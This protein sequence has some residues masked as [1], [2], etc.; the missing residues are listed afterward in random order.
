MR[1][2][3]D[4]DTCNIYSY[5]ENEKCKKLHSHCIVGAVWMK[6]QEIFMLYDSISCLYLKISIIL[7]NFQVELFIDLV[8]L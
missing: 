1:E 4:K 2:K 7:E 6:L 5:I 8:V 3:Q